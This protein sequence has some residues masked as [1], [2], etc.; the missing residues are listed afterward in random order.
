LALAPKVG[1][2]MS[3]RKKQ[4][5]KTSK[6]LTDRGKERRSRQL[7]KGTRGPAKGRQKKYS[8]RL[9]KKKVT[10]KGGLHKTLPP[11][12]REAP[13]R[14]KGRRQDDTG[15]QKQEKIRELQSMV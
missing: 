14:G 2:A 15:Q 12:G 11:D 8:T 6:V 1:P 10:Q 4:K 3:S 9:K 13:G 5:R 7:A